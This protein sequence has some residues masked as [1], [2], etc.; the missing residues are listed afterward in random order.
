MYNDYFRL[1]LPALSSHLEDAQL[2]VNEYRVGSPS[3][4]ENFLLFEVTDAITALTNTQATVTN[5]YADLG[6][7]NQYGGYSV[8]S[9]E[10][11]MF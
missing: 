1:I 5:I 6:S 3:G 7:G 4:I 2:S 8:F 10:S 11:G 9:S